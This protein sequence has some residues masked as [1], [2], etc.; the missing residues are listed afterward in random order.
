MN[1][2]EGDSE[3]SQIEAKVAVRITSALSLSPFIM[4]SSSRTSVYSPLLLGKMI[5]N[6][7]FVQTER[8]TPVE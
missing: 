6:A 3:L 5:G 2:E 4:L 8:V 1:F 7:Y